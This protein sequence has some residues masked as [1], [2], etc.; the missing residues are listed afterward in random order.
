MFIPA[1]VL[2][3]LVEHDWPGNIRELEN[4]IERAMILVTG[5]NRRGVSGHHFR[6]RCAEARVNSTRCS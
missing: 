3:T 4:V 1:H 2:Q 6:T 5:P